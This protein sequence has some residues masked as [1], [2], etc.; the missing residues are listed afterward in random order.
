MKGSALLPEIGKLSPG[1]HLASFFRDERER[2]AI[3][4]P[5][6]ESSLARGRRTFLLH[7]EHGLPRELQRLVSGGGRA[8]ALATSG[9]R[10]RYGA[11]P[12][13]DRLVGLPAGELLKGD[14]EGVE[15]CG[16]R[17]LEFV[18]EQARRAVAE[19][20]SGLAVACDMSCLSRHR[21]PFE[22]ASFER[23]YDEF[24]NCLPV[25]SLCEFD[26]SLW[27]AETLLELMGSH[28]LLALEEGSLHENIFYEGPGER[29]GEG[30][31]RQIL[32]RRLSRV[33]ERKRLESERDGARLFA[34]AIVRTIREPLLV[35]DESLKVVSAN[36]AFEAAFSVEL[37][38]V[39]GWDLDKLA[40][41][42][43]GS[44]ALLHLLTEVIPKSTSVEDLEL[45]VCLPRLGKRIFRLNARRVVDKERFPPFILVTLEDE[46]ERR[47][48]REML[49]ELNRTLLVLGSDFLENM[50]TIT[51]A[52]GHILG[53]GT[54][55]YIRVED[56][57][58]IGLGAGEGD[59]GVVSF[60]LPCPLIGLAEALGGYKQALVVKDITR[61]PA[62]LGE[63]P[64]VRHYGFVSYLGHPVSLGGK[65]VG[66]LSCYF[67]E[68]RDFGPEERHLAGILARALAIEEER[69]RKERSLKD[70]VDIAS[71]ELRHPLTLIKG[72][73]ATLRHLLPNAGTETID[74]VLKAV[75]LG[76]ERMNELVKKLLDLS[77]L[78]RG[79]FIA[80]KVPSDLCKLLGRAVEEARVERP[81]VRFRKRGDIPPVSADPEAIYKVA[82]ILLENA[83]KFSPH[84]TPV[85]VGVRLQGREVVVHVADR[86]P[87]VPPRLRNRI[88][89]KFVQAD[90]A[91]HHHTPGMGIGLYL[92]RE[93]VEA[94]GGRIW[95]ERRRGGGSVFRFT[96][97]LA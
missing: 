57:R 94:H 22:V 77:R 64:L 59:A 85:D 33:R 23:R 61:G 41:G 84:G 8:G 89:E 87:G 18:V 66:L 36:P 31:A 29:A 62:S 91:K 71:H 93:I 67:R 40:A 81:C 42:A 5:F 56:E 13:R 3:L 72:Y 65:T 97:P 1:D 82:V 9:T 7:G 49:E 55:F 2:M 19:G 11:S 30:E 60:S 73:A 35:L 79:K 15:P 47:R 38:Q 14:E 96:L 12:E 86:G 95:C 69:Y 52:C 78:E 76:A 90:P 10:Y 34:E 54:A 45:E 4:V 50:E 63:D 74:E 44:P 32:E 43:L 25:T 75:E 80:T 88:F 39:K 53:G 83:L 37:E 21:V 92:A 6:V 70:F 68:P 16:S 51:R 17:F 58:V 24:L 28:P 20:Y 46:T 48:Q 26:L 27:K